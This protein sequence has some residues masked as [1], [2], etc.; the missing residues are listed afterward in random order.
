LKKGINQS[1]IIQTINHL[2]LNLKH[3][4]V[5]LYT[6]VFCILLSGCAQITSLQTAKTLPKDEQIIGVSASAYGINQASFVGGDVGL[7]VYPHVEVFGRQGFSN[8]FD[9]GLKISSSGNIAIDGKYQFLGNAESKFALASGLALEY[10]FVPNFETFV[11]RQTVPV[12]VS[13]HPNSNFAVYVVPK[14][15]HQSLPLLEI[16][17]IKVVWVSYLIFKRLLNPRALHLECL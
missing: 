6:L 16:L 7:P 10:Q 4:G 15:M 12:Y 2:F 1:I 17:F 14:F 9:A 3:V 13:F 8:K 11:S 5:A